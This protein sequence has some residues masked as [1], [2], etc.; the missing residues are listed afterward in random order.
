MFLFFLI[1]KM[2]CI[3]TCW[4]ADGKNLVERGKLMMSDKIVQ[5][6]ESWS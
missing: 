3:I 6:Q 4:Y 1:F 2:R 5:L